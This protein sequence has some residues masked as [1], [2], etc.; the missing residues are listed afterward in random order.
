MSGGRRVALVVAAAAAVFLAGCES[1]EE[2]A[3]RFYRSALQ[4]LEQGDEERA[5]VELRNVFQN[6]GFHTEARLLY[7]D[8]SL[9]QG[10]EGE[11]YSHYMLLAE[12][13]PDMV[14]VRRTLAEIAIAQ[15]DWEEADR[16]G[17]EALRLLPDDPRI[18]ASCRSP[19]A[20]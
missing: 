13:Q 14:E 15:G 10:D 16:H 5:L 20:L 2:K 17:S 12:Q 3:E 8:L 18:R 9:Q 6:D 7:A 1:R 19:G 11:A 4:L